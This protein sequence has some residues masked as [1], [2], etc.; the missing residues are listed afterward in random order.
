MMFRLKR[1]QRR[2]NLFQNQSSITET[3]QEKV[4]TKERERERIGSIKLHERKKWIYENGCGN[5]GN[6][7][8]MNLQMTLNWELANRLKYILTQNAMK[9]SKTQ[10]HKTLKLTAKN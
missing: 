10:T 5:T 2:Q 1:L 8:E 9:R 4:Q 7:L 3:E 6:S